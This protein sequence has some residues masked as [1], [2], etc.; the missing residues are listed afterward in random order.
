MGDGTLSAAPLV[1]VVMVGLRFVS[2]VKVGPPVLPS[3]KACV[4]V[5]TAGEREAD[6]SPRVRTLPGGS[7]A[8]I[9][10]AAKH[11]LGMTVVQEQT[12]KGASSI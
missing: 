6:S 7:L 12:G 2:S 10:P 8:L 4:L 1:P 9:R 5:S 3:D 11:Q